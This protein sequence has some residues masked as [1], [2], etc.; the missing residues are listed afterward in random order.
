MIT[1]TLGRLQK[2]DLRDSWTSESSDFTPW[3]AQEENLKQLGEAFGIDLELEAQEKDIGP[4]RADILC[5]D[6]A[7]DNWA[8]ARSSIARRRVATRT[9][10]FRC[11][12]IS[13][14]Q[15]FACGSMNRQIHGGWASL[16]KILRVQRRVTSSFK[17]RTG[18]ILTVREATQPEA[19]LAPL[20]TALALNPNPGGTRK[21]IV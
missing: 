14:S 12:P 21:L 1:A 15:S 16:R 17:M 19:E 4:F 7:T 6:T 3:L 10:S 8:C 13:A 2:V 20:Y 11:S 18:R 9:C 5:K